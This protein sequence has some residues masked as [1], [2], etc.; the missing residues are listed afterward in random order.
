[1]I[2]KEEFY[3]DSRDGIHKIRAMKWIPEGEIKCVL[4]FIHGM[5]EHIDR[6]DEFATYLAERGILVVG[7]DHLGHGKSV[8]SKEEYG[9]FC[10]DDAYTVVI[11]DVHRLKKLTQEDNPG[12]KYFIFGHSMGSLILRNYLFRYGKGIDGAIVCGTASQPKSVTVPG[13]LLLKVMALFMGWEARSQFAS[14]LVLGKPNKKIESQKT[15]SDWL[16]TDTKKVKEYLDD[17]ACGFLFTLNGFHTLVSFVLGLE[18]KKEYKKIPK[19]LP[20]LFI[21]GSEDPVG[22]YS[23]GV[24]RAYRQITDAGMTNVKIKLYDGMRHEI[25]NE[26]GRDNVYKDVFAYV[27]SLI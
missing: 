15:E 25:H 13:I 26:V 5:A 2:K 18:N 27:E 22:N 12:K 9:Y 10:K 16:S 4:Q 17:D 8:K 21:S 14:K 6:Y 7:N 3:Y 11:R 20:I 24:K 23:E 19:E 1:M